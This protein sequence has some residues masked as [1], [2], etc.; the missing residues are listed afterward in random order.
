MGQP[1]LAL[2]FGEEVLLQRVCRI[3]GEVVQPIVVVAAVEQ[4]LPSLPDS[5]RIVRDDYDSLGPLA[6]IATGLDALQDDCESAFVTSCDVPLLRPEFVRAIVSR[7]EAHDAAVPND[8]YDHVLA[9]AYRT[10]L[11]AKARALLD[12]GQRRPLRLI[13]SV[14]CCRIPVD[15]LRTADPDLDSLRNCNT[16]D[17]YHAVLKL[18]GLAPDSA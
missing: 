17:E 13:D 16:P 12:S 10:E 5:I 4:Q 3:L 15:E 11:A 14:N 2:P 8:K 7:M 6:G 9:A 18:A 1:K